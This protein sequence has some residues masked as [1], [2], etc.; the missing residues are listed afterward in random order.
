MSDKTP[1]FI[2]TSST[3]LSRLKD[4]DD[5]GSWQLFAN[6]YS[7]LIYKTAIQAGL[8]EAEAQDVVQDTLVSVAKKMHDFQYD[9]ALGSFKGWLLQLTGWRIKNQLKKRLPADRLEPLPAT[10]TRTPTATRIA[11]PAVSDMAAFWDAEWQNNLM[12]AAVERV[13]Q[14]VNPRLYEIFHLHVVRK[15]PAREVA[16]TLNVNV[17]RVYLAKHRVTA[18]VK[19][20]V[21]RLELQMF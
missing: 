17:A 16:K 9:P 8:N 12:D 19:K 21:R 11:D 7:K 10:G 2:P 1:E 13:K 6:T 20:E 3:L 5:A 4:W 14:N 15:L 18:L